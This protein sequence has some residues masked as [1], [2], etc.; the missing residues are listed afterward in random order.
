MQFGADLT[1]I[2]SVNGDAGR[3]QQVIGN[4][5]TNALKFTPEGGRVDV[6][7][8]RVDDD[9]EV[10]VADTGDG[11]EPAF[12]PHVFEQ[13]RQAD[14]SGAARRQGG[15]GLGL[16]LVRQLVEL[17]GGTVHAASEGKGRGATFTIRLPT[18]Q[19]ATGRAPALMPPIPA[20]STA[21][22]A[23]ER[24]DGVTVLVVDDNLDGRTLAA[25]LLTH[26]GARVNTVASVHEALRALQTDAPD[27][28]VT[29][30]GLP[31]EDGYALLRQ[32][33][34]RHDQFIPAIA[35]TG[36]GG[37]EDRR[38]VPAAGFQAH[39]IKPFEPAELI[40]AIGSLSRA[41]KPR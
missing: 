21:D 7:L 14:A 37:A 12:L 24:L 41:R 10:T 3:L 29:D 6:S 17:H 31:D 28:L 25:V 22:V 11:I 27:V 38:R 39:I 13:F 33:R 9:V 16:A 23:G 20:S 34:L 2:N 15:L 8:A 19:T 4:L 1:A 36:Y 35:L 26:H 5:L 32:M 30:I 40:A 18:G